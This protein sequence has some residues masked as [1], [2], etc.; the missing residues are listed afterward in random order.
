MLGHNHTASTLAGLVFAVRTVFADASTRWP[1]PADSYAP[2]LTQQKCPFAGQLFPPPTAASSAPAI[3]AAQ[4]AL[5][6]QLDAAV[7]PGGGIEG[8][9]VNGTFFSVAVFSA[10]DGEEGAFF[11][12]HYAVPG[13]E[14]ATGGRALDGESVYRIGSVSKMLTVYA[15]LAERGDGDFGTP[16]TDFMPDLGEGQ[17]GADEEDEFERIRWEDI[18]IEFLQ[19]LNKLG[20]YFPAFE[21]P[22]YSNAGF[23]LLGY[24][25]ENM[26]GEPFDTTFKRTIADKL[27]LSAT[28]VTTPQDDS[29]GVIPNGKTAAW[30]GLDLGE[31]NPA[32]SIYSTTADMTALGRSILRSTL[33]PRALTRRWLKPHSRTSDDA[34]HVGAPWE[35][36]STRIPLDATSSSSATTR[37]DLYTKTGNVGAYS[38]HIGLD[39]DRD[40]GYVVLGAGPASGAPVFYLA[41]LAARTFAP[42]FE[43]AARAQ[44][45][46]R[47]AG[48]YVGGGNGTLTLAVR[49]GAPGLAVTA[50]TANGV[51]VLAALAVPGL[52]GNTSTAV[53]L[54]PARMRGSGRVA[55]RALLEPLPNADFGG[56]LESACQSWFTADAAQIA[57]RMLDEVVVGVDEETGRAEWVEMRAWRERYVRKE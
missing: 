42:A 9:D 2:V 35:I 53:T 46:Q 27:G 1:Q 28:T 21:S 38:G 13:M 29:R 44:A 33:L 39:P 30:W 5:R 47:Y 24:A 3:L 14:N 16:I 23:R 41:D 55:F 34:H 40:W 15:L 25:M 32:G 37:V 20:A 43:A 6:A 17:E 31:E 48:T 51:D 54:Y 26:T 7:Q 49:P 18:T 22:T 19:G 10:A 52:A 56:P 4:S 45:A 50:W 12:Y 57:S 36:A 8:V 11:E